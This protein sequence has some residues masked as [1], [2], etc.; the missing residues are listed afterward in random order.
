MVFIGIYNS[1][2]FE[3]T[4]FGGESA[5][6]DLEVICELLAVEGDIEAAASRGFGA[7]GEVSEELIARCALRGDLYALV[8]AEILPCKILHNII[9][10]Q[11]A[12]SI[13]YSTTTRLTMLTVLHRL[14]Y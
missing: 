9:Y 7:N 12:M 5:A 1:L 11:I 2:A 8:E 3:L 6:L 10:H 14:R 13:P 4:Y